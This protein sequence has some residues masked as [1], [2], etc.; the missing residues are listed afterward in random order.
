MGSRLADE[1]AGRLLRAQ[2]K[3]NHKPPFADRA[4]INLAP[5]AHTRARSIT[6]SILSPQNGLI[7]RT[8][9]SGRKHK[10]PVHKQRL[11]F[12]W[13]TLL[14]CA[15]LI[16]A[17]ELSRGS[18]LRTPQSTSAAEH[19]C[20]CADTRVRRTR[21]AEEACVEPARLSSIGLNVAKDN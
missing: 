1:K 16:I 18:R 3:S 10:K 12:A 19:I 7:D 6:H 17:I 13:R 8:R 14:K 9:H 2:S 11:L 5:A 15:P 21:H 4:S 20:C